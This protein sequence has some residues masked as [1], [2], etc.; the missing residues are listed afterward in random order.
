M[1]TTPEDVKITV[2]QPDKVMKCCNVQFYLKKILG[3]GEM[4]V[5]AE[6]ENGVYDVKHF[7]WTLR[8]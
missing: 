1:E 5:M 6:L 4:L 2:E 8:W 3:K 7:G